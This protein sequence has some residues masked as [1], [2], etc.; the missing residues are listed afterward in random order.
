MLIAEHAEKNVGEEADA[1][2]RSLTE[3]AQ[4]DAEKNDDG[5]TPKDA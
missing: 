3:Q 4:N 5:D 2:L 1:W